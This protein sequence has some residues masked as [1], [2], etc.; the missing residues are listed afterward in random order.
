M[1]LNGIVPCVLKTKIK[2]I[3]GVCKTIKVLKTGLTNALKM[4]YLEEKLF[5]R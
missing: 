5:R 1:D 2:G 4:T 3:V